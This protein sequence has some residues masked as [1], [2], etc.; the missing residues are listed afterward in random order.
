LQ[1]LKILENPYAYAE[2]LDH[3]E[4]V[5]VSVELQRKSEKTQQST[6]RQASRRRPDVDIERE[7]R[8]LHLRIWR[9]RE[10]V[11]GEAVPQDPIGLLDPVVALEMLGYGCE[12]VEGLGKDRVK[13]GLIDVAGLID[14]PSRRVVVSRQFSPEIRLFTL[15]HELGHATLHPGATGVHRD[16]P[17]SGVNQSTEVIEIE[18][19]RFAGFFLMPKK[20]VVSNFIAIYGAS[21]FVLNDETWFALTGLTVSEA[22][23]RTTRDLSRLLANAETYNGRH[24]QSLASRFRVSV[25]AMAIRLEELALVSAP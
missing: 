19:N 4:K 17:L 10:S 15:A 12:F 8:K 3:D 1:S 13:E 23:I 6:A 20:L 18:A 2:L 24:F 7:A 22:Q 5:G 25:E 11:W 16:R 21:P 9:E 14:Q